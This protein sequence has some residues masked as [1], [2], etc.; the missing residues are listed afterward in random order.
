MTMIRFT[1]DDGT[2]V[3]TVVWTPEYGFMAAGS[4][5]HLEMIRYEEV[6]PR[7]QGTVSYTN[8]PDPIPIFTVDL[9]NGPCGACGCGEEQHEYVDGDGDLM[10]SCERHDCRTYIP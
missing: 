8:T 3:T 5:A 1:F 4:R 6:A 7:P 10:T 2:D 9:P